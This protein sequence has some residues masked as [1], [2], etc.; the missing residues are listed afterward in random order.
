MTTADLR[1]QIAARTAAAISEARDQLANGW[2][3]TEVLA[4]AT[5]AWSVI[6]DLKDQ[7]AAAEELN[8][9]MLRPLLWD[10]ACGH[11]SPNHQDLRC[12]LHPG[13]SMKVGHLYTVKVTR[14]AA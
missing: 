7:V 11:Q 3:D 6:A 4:V 5:D 8:L 2:T 1:A 13:H 12:Y 10:T 9:D 14:R